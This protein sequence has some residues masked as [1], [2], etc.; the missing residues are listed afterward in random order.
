MERRN[1]S[2]SCI[3]AL[4]WLYF[5]SVVSFSPNYRV[6]HHPIS[7]ITSR[8]IRRH[9]GGE[10]SGVTDERCEQNLEH[11]KDRPP[12]Q[13][14]LCQVWKNQRLSLRTKISPLFAVP[15]TDTPP[16]ENRSGIIRRSLR[17]LFFFPLVSHMLKLICN[18]HPSSY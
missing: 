12:I 14:Q 8:S 3:L 6:H 9:F 10:L 5:L 4:L 18:I 13:R 15:S 16:A 11:G 1:R 17:K 7:K 2:G